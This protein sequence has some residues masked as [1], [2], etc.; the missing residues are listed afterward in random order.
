MVLEQGQEGLGEKGGVRRTVTLA[1]LGG[2]SWNVQD[3]P[4]QTTWHKVVVSQGG[5]EVGGN[6][7]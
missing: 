7:V 4:S 3:D 1:H 2:S 6:P 5:Q